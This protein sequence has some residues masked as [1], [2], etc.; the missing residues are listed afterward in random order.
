MR[1]WRLQSLITKW[2]TL[3]E[4]FF[5]ERRRGTNAR[6]PRIKAAAPAENSPPLS[7]STAH[8]SIRSQ[9]TK[10]ADETDKTNMS[11]QPG[12]VDQPGRILL[13]STTNAGVNTGDVLV[14]VPATASPEHQEGPHPSPNGIGGNSSMLD[15]AVTTPPGT[16]GLANKGNE[17]QADLAQGTN[18]GDDREFEQSADRVGAEPERITRNES[19]AEKIALEASNGATFATRP[20]RTDAKKPPSPSRTVEP[21]QRGGGRFG[22]EQERYADREGTRREPNNLEVVCERRDRCW[23][24]AIQMSGDA[25][26][27]PA[28]LWQEGKKLRSGAMTIPYLR[29]PPSRV[30]FM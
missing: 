29:L 11:V 17:A 18:G 3:V 22:V 13:D 20:A 8:S 27:S 19:K 28:E 5:H 10:P 25:V 12:P 15:A 14:Q 6:R 4:R 2:A 26:E 1:H 21:P 30:Q 23:T 9:I 7:K 24:V 16:T